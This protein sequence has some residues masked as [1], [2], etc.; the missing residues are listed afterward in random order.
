[1]A[2]VACNNNSHVD[3]HVEKFKINLLD[4]DDQQDPVL[5]VMA[6]MPHDAMTI[7]PLPSWLCSRR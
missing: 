2:C 1:V 4:M 7:M 6:A 3:L 5:H